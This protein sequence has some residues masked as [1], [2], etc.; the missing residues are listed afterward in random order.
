MR[1][2]ILAHTSAVQD[3]ILYAS[4]FDANAAIFETLLSPEDAV[5]SDEL[6][7]AS[8]I[9]GIRLCRFSLVR[10][11]ATLDTGVCCSHLPWSLVR[12]QARPSAV[13]T[14]TAT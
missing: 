1:L 12:H 4:C 9:D 3:T 7:H 10:P 6:N 2:C 11:N 14:S 8:I 13:A 5:F